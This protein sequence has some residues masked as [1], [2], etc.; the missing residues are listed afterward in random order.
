[1]R[2]NP[3][4]SPNLMLDQSFLE[5]LPGDV[6]EAFSVLEMHLRGQIPAAREFN[7]NDSQQNYDFERSE[8]QK[9]YVIHLAAFAQVHQLNV[10]VDFDELIILEDYPFIN[11]FRTAS[12]KIQMFASMCAFK[13]TE[14][15]KAGS[16]CIYVITAGTKE[17]IRKH[18][19][20]I[21]VLIDAGEISDLKR[22]ALYS[23]LSNFALEVDRDRT[24]V[25]SLASL[26]IQAKKEF[27]GESEVLK[28][29]EKLFDLISSGGKELWKALPEI[30]ITARL[31]APKKRISG[32]DKDFDLDD[33]IPF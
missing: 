28:K 18:I 27:P 21:K 31:E 7:D 11:M 24:R 5:A 32:P 15:K 3:D 25:E 29:L 20:Q 13:L 14:R 33:E 23:K 4:Q 17:R 12:V 2:E 22:D 6:E 19:D 16:T 30:K 9:Q 26:Y 8:F 10:G 1:M